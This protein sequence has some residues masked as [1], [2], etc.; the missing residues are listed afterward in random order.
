MIL[1]DITINIYFEVNIES[2]WKFEWPLLVLPRVFQQELRNILVFLVGRSCMIPSQKRLLSFIHTHHC[3][4]LRSNFISLLY[5]QTL[6]FHGRPKRH[7]AH[8]FSFISSSRP[9]PLLAA[10]PL[11]LFLLDGAHPRIVPPHQPSKRGAG[12]PSDQKIQHDYHLYQMGVPKMQIA[13]KLSD[14]NVGLF[15]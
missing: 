14:F 8:L 15:L 13:A 11:L 2:C 5:A 12:T 7:Q 9:R 4:I 6:L 10:A 1:V 3:I